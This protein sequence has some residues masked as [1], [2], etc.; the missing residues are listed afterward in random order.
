MKAKNSIK[1]DEDEIV[2][3]TTL[4]TWLGVSRRR[5]EQLT[6]EGVIKPI[7]TSP[8]RFR[9]RETVCAYVKHLSAKAAGRPG[10]TM[11]EQE[12]SKA[13]LVAEADL[14]QSKAEIARMELD[15]IKGRLHRSD[16]VEA[17]TNNLAL[18]V[19]SAVLALPG[20]LAMDLAPMTSANEISAR[21]KA[22]CDAVLNDLSR[23]KYDRGEY[24]KRSR[25]RIGWESDLSSDDE[26]DDDE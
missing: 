25:A 20:R 15:E 9:L 22:E 19:R 16:D 26:E 3:A 11:T 18:N 2:A 13:K 5:V 17:M 14:K 12:A 8:I 6:A 1:T 7:Q 10:K 23:Y 24:M 21:I 4:A